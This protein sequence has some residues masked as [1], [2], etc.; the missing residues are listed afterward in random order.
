MARFLKNSDPR[1][2]LVE[3]RSKGFLVLVLGMLLAV[4]GFA[5]W[6][7]EWF[8]PGRTYRMTAETSEGLQQGMAVRLS[9]FR[10]GKVANIELVGAKRV[11]VD[12][13]VFAEYAGYVREDSRAKV[14]GENLIGDR[15]IE[16]S[17][18]SETSP[19]A[20]EGWTI[21]IEAE[22]TIGAMVEELKRDF[23]PILAGLGTVAER[24]PQTVE[25]IDRVI[26][27]T[28]ALVVELRSDEGDLMGGLTNFNEAVAEIEQLAV[29]LRAPQ[30]DLMQGI[31]QFEQAT[32]TLNDNMGSIV[33]KLDTATG[34]LGD[35]ADQ[36]G[37]LFSD[38]NV[39]VGQL[40]RTIDE[41][42]PAVPGMVRKGSKAVDKADD[43]MTAVRNMWPIRKGVPD[44]DEPVLRTGSDD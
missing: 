3:L 43:V 38:A 17:T 28:Q 39:V 14:R 31:D 40:G 37:K 22:P 25:R 21:A 12:V 7:Q 5:V 26:D 18:G 23:E 13:V 10:I 8:R 41:T 4:V 36:A 20:P 30:N 24:L 35:A 34:T 6:K 27:E 15:F 1:F 19:Q 16:L 11:G 32:R 42:A 44:D 9:G 33:T 29:D 2:H